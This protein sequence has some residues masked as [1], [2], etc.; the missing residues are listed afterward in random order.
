MANE[1]HSKAVGG[2]LRSL[3]TAIGSA[4]AF[5]GLVLICTI[6]YAGWSSNRSAIESERT[7]VSNAVN[8]SIAR[9][10]SEQ[11]SVAW[12]DDSVQQI[13]KE[14]NPDWVDENIGLFLVE[15][16]GQDEL[17]IV[18]SDGTIRYGYRSEGRMDPPDQ[19]NR[20]PEIQA[21]L[22]EVLRQAPARLIE[23]P[24]AFGAGQNSYAVLRGARD[25]ARWAGHVLSIDGKPAIVTAITIRANVTPDLDVAEPS[26]LLSVVFIDDEF[27]QGLGRLL[28]LPDLTLSQERPTDASLVTEAFVSDEGRTAGY[29]SW[30]PRRPGQVLLAVI[31]PLVVLGLLGAGVLTATMLRRLSRAST[32]LANREAEAVHLAKHD[33]LSGLPNRH[34]FAERISGAIHRLRPDDKRRIV[35]AY[36]DI[37]RF[38]DINDT[39]GHQ[40]GDELIRAVGQR[41]RQHVGSADFLARFGGDEFAVLSTTDS[42]SGVSRLAG[43]LMEAFQEPFPVGGQSVHITASVGLSSAPDHGMSGDTL[44]QSA[45]IAL[46]AAKGAGRNQTMVFS[47]EMAQDVQRRRTVETDLQAAIRGNELTLHYQPVISCAS[48]RIT[49][50]EALLR[51]NHPT[52]GSIPPSVFIPVAEEAGLMPALGAWV[53]ER[54]FADYA[55]LP[56]ID[57]CINLSPAQLRSGSI[58]NHLTELARRHGVLTHRIVFEITETALMN[59]SSATRETMNFIRAMGFQLALDDF[60]TGYSSLRYLCDYKFD[61]LKIDRSFVSEIN[62]TGNALAIV[63]SAVQLGRNLGIDVVA[64]GV[65]SEAEAAAMR[66]LGCTAMQGYYFGR[67]VPLDVLKST[68]LEAQASQPPVNARSAQAG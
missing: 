48:N 64:E 7:L 45:D 2:N 10:L 39:L 22:D 24:D 52:Q 31:L 11:K 4:I 49:G 27:I 55:R 38:K 17:Y 58:R 34:F 50:V 63:Q 14:L 54:A 62:D 56:N 57:V 28:L 61:R 67:P 33:S 12:W 30:T 47:D 20:K 21:L 51:W 8:Q 26:Y 3:T 9:V 36:L 25:S 53:L 44:M 59:S 32:E 40:A 13:D 42:D 18:G 46:Y 43:R 29:L 15:T 19:F 35:I 60:G 6:G 37:D 68:M 65:E 5:F 41:L 23:R 1:A 66:F 16:Y